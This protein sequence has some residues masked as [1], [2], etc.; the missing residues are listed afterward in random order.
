MSSDAY[1]LVDPLYRE[2]N[3][4]IKEEYFRRPAATVEYLAASDNLASALFLGV[5]YFSYNYLAKS[6]ST[7]FFHNRVFARHLTALGFSL[8]VRDRL[9]AKFVHSSPR[10]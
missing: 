6:A 4:Q 2:S 9:K 5:W 1:V 3:L 10:V 8:L 7:S